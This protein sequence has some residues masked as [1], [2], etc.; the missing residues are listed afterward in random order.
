MDLGGLTNLRSDLRTAKQHRRR[1]LNQQ[2]EGYN[3]DAG[4]REKRE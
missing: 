2:T 4:L 1:H 3:V